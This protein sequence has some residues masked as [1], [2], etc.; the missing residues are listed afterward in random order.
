MMD[1]VMVNSQD[2]GKR[3]ER[4]VVRFL[5]ENGFPD[6]R[7]TKA[8]QRNDPGDVWP[9]GMVAP[10]PVI[11]SV[12]SGYTRDPHPGTREWQEWWGSLRR[13]CDMFGSIGLLCHARE[14]KSSP[15]YW[16]W[17][18]DLDLGFFTFPVDGP[19]QITGS[20]ALQWMRGRHDPPP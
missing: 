17:W 14:G 8:G 11:V 13:T 19:V 10:P 9:Y 1:V 6:V 16:R 20:Q 18:T 3:A 4:A 12:K 15:L 2:K 7:R 5:A